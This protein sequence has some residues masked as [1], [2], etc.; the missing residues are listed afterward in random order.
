MADRG[1]IG[2]SFGKLK[3]LK[4]LLTPDKLVTG[5][6]FGALLIVI[7]MPAKP[8]KNKN[9]GEEKTGQTSEQEAFDDTDAMYVLDLENR[10]KE[11]LSLVSGIGKV[12]VMITLKAT[13]EAVLNKDAPFRRENTSENDGTAVKQQNSY[14]CQ[15]ETVL[16]E[17]EGDTR[18]F[19]LK[20]FYP[21][22]EGVLVVAQG[23]DQPAVK[24]EIIE[25]AQVLFGVE[26]HKVEVLGMD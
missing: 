20:S 12:E 21:E 25:A 6:L 2:T 24:N 22:I 14:E 16:V 10:L 23:A 18:P 11:T 4:K 5:I 1:S 7:A 19:V 17:E 9:Q 3:D 13:G 15:E 8:G 26:A